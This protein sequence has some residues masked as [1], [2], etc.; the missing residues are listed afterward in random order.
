MVGA[1]VDDV[2]CSESS[3]LARFGFWAFKRLCALLGFITSGRKGQT[4]SA[5]MHFIGADVSLLKNAIRT[6]ETEERDGELR[7]R[8]SQALLLNCLTPEAASRLRGV[9]GFY[10]SLLMGRLGRG[11]MGPLI[12]RQYGANS[13][14]LTCE[15][16]RN[17]L[18]RYNV[19]GK[20]PP[21]LIPLAM[22]APMGAHSDAQGFGHVAS[23]A[24]LPDDLTVSTHLPQWFID[25]ALAAEGE[26]PIYLFELAAAILA[27]CL[28]ILHN[29]GNTRACVLC[30]DNKAA[31][32]ALIKGSSSSL[33]GAILVNVFRS[34]PARFPIVWRLEYVNT[35]SNAADPPSRACDAP[36]GKAC[37][38]SSGV[39]PPEF[40]RICSSWSVLRRES[41]L[42]TN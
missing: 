37:D 2:F 8:I 32:S 20:P 17:L 24:L 22:L 38:L 1:Y 36:L 42:A 14:T 34:M 5:I 25:M 16:N 10:T 39:I 9:L 26:S 13:I 33:L 23:R 12:R 19:I 3:Y 27:A 28:V 21:R 18:W 29:D 11:M 31:L 40:S 41:I 35:K 7:G 6:R 15:L 30:V 4:P